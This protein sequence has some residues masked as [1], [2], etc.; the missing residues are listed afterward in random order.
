MISQNTSSATVNKPKILPPASSIPPPSKPLFK[1]TSGLSLR[2]KVILSAIALSVIPV[3]LIGMVAYKV[4]ASHVARQINLAELNRT[5]HLSDMVGKYIKNQAKTAETLASSP[6]F[7][8]PNVIDTVTLSQKQEALATFQAQTGVY[9]RI[10]YLDIQGNPQFQS[11]SDDSMRNNYSDRQIFQRAIAMKQTSMSELII[12]PT[13]GEGIIEYAVPVKNA[14][15]A[16]VIGVMYFQMPRDKLTPLFTS[17]VTSEEKWHLINSQGIFFASAINNLKNQPIADYYPQLK[18]AHDSKKVVAFQALSPKI[19][20]REQIIDYVPVNLGKINPQLNLGTVIALDTDIAFAPLKPLGLIFFGGTIGTAILVGSIAGFLANRI[21]QPLLKL[22]AA[23]GQLSQ[24]KLD[25]RIELQ[26]QDELALL[27]NQIDDM[28]EQL[29]IFMER[30]QSIAKTSELM[31]QMSQSRST[32]ELQLPFSLFL[33]EVRRLIK[34][35][36]VI[37][38]QFDPQWWGTVIAE[39]VSEGFPRTLGV[40]FDDPCFAQEYVRKYQRGRIQAVEDIYQA[41]LTDCHLQQLEPYGVKASLVL[42]VILEGR[43]NLEP[44]R[45]IG[46]L[47]AHQCSNTRVWQQSD[48]D[49]LQQ[50]AYQLAMV[51]RGYIQYKDENLQKVSMQ[52]DFAQILNTMKQMSEGDLT[53]D[54]SSRVAQTTD[55]TQSFDNL[56]SNIRQTITKIKIPSQ[57]INSQLNG[58]KKD[59]ADIRE[60]LRQQ[61]NQLVLIFTFMEQIGQGIQ[62]IAAKIELTSQ[63]VNS[64]ATD[65]EAE[66]ANCVQEISSM[67]QLQNTLRN[68]IDKVSNLRSASQK[69]TRV[70]TSIKKI[71]LRASLL[72]SKLSKRIP[73]VE[74]STFGLKEEIESIQQSIAATKELENVVLGIEQ[75]IS[76]VFQDYE[77]SANQ[78]SQENYLVTHG[79]SNMDQIF[80]TTKNIQQHLFSLINMTNIQIQTTQKISTLQD[81]LDETNQSLSVL[82]DRA[83]NSLDTTSITARDLENFTYFFK[84]DKAS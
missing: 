55:I 37:F 65:I 3:G 46:L 40:E 82:G 57:E 17:Y 26:G 61:A 84:L 12:S 83:S 56:L 71:N 13:T 44:E 58:S 81:E 76:Q 47:I 36:R 27:G 78:L 29:N 31:A 22:T 30:Q 79:K 63:T 10:V 66:K 4:T 67:A 74:D 14:W 80:K 41:N 64:V 53:V 75:E 43:T 60:Q 39:S 77:V 15:T 1:K 72:A 34:A 2:S 7:T 20:E 70:I 73:Q 50:V 21:I 51:L 48:V 16:E 62:E 25:T 35:D 19:S 8:N 6:I 59:V 28:A 38:Y 42:P 52:Q 49:Y 54:L 11:L 9:D 24:G 32:R 45:L 33:A 18:K 69:M 23:V 68:N 5:R